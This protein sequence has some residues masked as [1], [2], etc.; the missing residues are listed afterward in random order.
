MLLQLT[1]VNKIYNGA[2][3]LKH[4]SLTIEDRDRIGLIGVNG[5]GKS[6]LLKLLMRFYKIGY[7]SYEK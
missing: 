5:C 4:I 3:L 7:K 1:D 6:T 2:P